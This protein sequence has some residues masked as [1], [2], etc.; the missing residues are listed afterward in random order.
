MARNAIPKY[1]RHASGQAR[2]TLT[3]KTFYLGKWGSPS[4]KSKYDELL[5]EWIRNGRSWPC[6]AEVP[7]DERA[8]VLSFPAD[9]SQVLLA[10]ICAGFLQHCHR[11][12]KGTKR[13]TSGTL[14]TARATVREL[15]PWY[16]IAWHEF[17]PRR[18][19][20]FRSAL[21]EAGKSRVGINRCCA[22]V[23]TIF[24][25]AVNEELLAGEVPHRLQAVSGL[26]RNESAAP[27]LEAVKPVAD[28]IIKRTTPNPLSSLSSVR[29]RPSGR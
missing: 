26:R 1:R 25:W 7:S 17:G 5:A 11:R 28:E 8:Q 21:V 13:L 12:V 23:K 22:M 18:L 6:D 16:A 29:G 20:E 14:G 27:E 15:K 9:T 10:D 4:S 3:G 2:V 19:K 24:K